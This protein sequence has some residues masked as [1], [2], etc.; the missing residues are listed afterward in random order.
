MIY[1]TA[2]FLL[3]LVAMA[4][5]ERSAKYEL[6]QQ[7][8]ILLLKKM[9][10]QTVVHTS[11]KEAKNRPFKSGSISETYYELNVYDLK[12]VRASKSHYTPCNEEENIMAIHC[13]VNKLFSHNQKYVRMFT[14]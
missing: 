7:Y 4:Y 2:A 6:P 12:H 3:L 5:G 9:R 1:S 13:V 14:F 8:L 11:D 10:P